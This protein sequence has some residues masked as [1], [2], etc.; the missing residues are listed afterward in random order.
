MVVPSAAVDVEADLSRTDSMFFNGIAFSIFPTGHN[1]QS[2]ENVAALLYLNV[3]AEKTESGRMSE[4]LATKMSA[5][6]AA[7]PLPKA[8][9][10]FGP[11]NG[12]AVSALANRQRR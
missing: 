2:L 3:K 11:Q 4:A 7:P 10:H 12:T 5:L 9:L 1:D 8:V 6:T